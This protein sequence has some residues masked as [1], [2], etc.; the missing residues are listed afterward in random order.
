MT[1]VSAVDYRDEG[2]FSLSHSVKGTEKQASKRM[3][4]INCRILKAHRQLS[5]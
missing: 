1:I 2:V 4:M 5:R 3:I